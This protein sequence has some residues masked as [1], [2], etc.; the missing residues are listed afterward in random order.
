MSPTTATI[1]VPALAAAPIRSAAASNG[2]GSRPSTTTDQPAPASPAANAS[3]SPRDAP[4]TIA[5][6]MAA[7]P[8]ERRVRSTGEY[9]KDL[10]ALLH[11]PG[12]SAGHA[13]SAGLRGG[14]AHGF[15]DRPAPDVVHGVGQLDRELRLEDGCGRPQPGQ[16]AQRRPHSFGQPRD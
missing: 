4:V 8:S 1:R 10:L 13:V 3:P 6:L 15:L 14:P 16:L 2:A 9:N 12:D 5:T 11:P 7:H